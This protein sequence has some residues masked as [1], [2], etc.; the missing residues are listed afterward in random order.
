VVLRVE[1]RP[2]DI[3]ASELFRGADADGRLADRADVGR[4]TLLAKGFSEIDPQAG[5]S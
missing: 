2:T 5:T 4:R 3:V 1:Y